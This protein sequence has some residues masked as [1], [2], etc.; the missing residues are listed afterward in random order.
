MF[1]LKSFKSFVLK[2]LILKGLRANFT[3]VRILKGIGEKQLKVEGLKLKGEGSGKLNTKTQSTQRSE[4]GMDLETEAGLAASM[5][6]GS[7][8]FDYCQGNS[9]IIL[10]FELE[11]GKWSGWKGLERIRELTADAPIFS[12]AAWKYDSIL[13]CKRS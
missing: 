5:G 11:T 8:D 7:A 3:K 2:L 13:R 6:D 10:S 4:M 9:T 1:I 12:L